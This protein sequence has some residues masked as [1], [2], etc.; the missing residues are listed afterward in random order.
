MTLVPLTVYLPRA[1]L[2]QLERRAAMAGF[3]RSS[4]AARAIAAVLSAPSLTSETIAQ[5]LS[6]LR[7]ETERLARCLGGGSDDRA[8]SNGDLT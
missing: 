8:A 7:A 5:E 4:F 2:V 6:S 3:S 1:Q